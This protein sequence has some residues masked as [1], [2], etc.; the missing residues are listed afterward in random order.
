MDRTQ[1]VVKQML[2]DSEITVMTSMNIPSTGTKP[3]LVETEISHAGEQKFVRR[4]FGRF[5][6]R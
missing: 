3:A 4:A 6:A 2:S 1:S 5:S